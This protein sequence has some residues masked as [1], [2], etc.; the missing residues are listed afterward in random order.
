MIVVN[1][2]RQLPAGCLQNRGEVLH[3]NP[4]VL[5]CTVSCPWSGSQRSTVVAAEGCGWA[6]THARSNVHKHEWQVAV[7]INHVPEPVVLVAHLDVVCAPP[8]ALE[9]CKVLVELVVLT[10]VH[11]REIAIEGSSG[12]A[13]RQLKSQWQSRIA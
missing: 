7:L 1:C 12:S 4:A 13:G 8:A 3:L 11:F 9:E 6:I 10:G 2:R 5:A